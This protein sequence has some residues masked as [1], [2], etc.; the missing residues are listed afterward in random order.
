VANSPLHAAT[1]KPAK[2]INMPDCRP[3]IVRV[4]KALSKPATRHTTKTPKLAL[5]S[6][7]SAMVIR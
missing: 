7:I 5:H 4:T 2:K 6:A 3:V 1:N